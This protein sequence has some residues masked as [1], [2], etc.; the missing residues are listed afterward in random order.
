MAM[1]QQ[2]PFTFSEMYVTKWR[3]TN[4]DQISCKVSL[5]TKEERLHKVFGL[6]AL[7]L[8]CNGNIKH[9]LIMGKTSLTA[10]MFSMYSTVWWYPGT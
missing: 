8:D 6:I 7:E 4:C 9:R 1:I 2:H 5:G 3:L 10:F